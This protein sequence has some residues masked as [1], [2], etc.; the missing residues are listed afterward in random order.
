MAGRFELVPIELVSNQS[1]TLTVPQI[2]RSQTGTVRC[3]VANYFSQIN[4]TV[5][6]TINVQ[7]MYY[8][9]KIPK[10]A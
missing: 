9:C 3:H 8:L 2:K 4:K 1:R 6:V 10:W 5:D 7:C